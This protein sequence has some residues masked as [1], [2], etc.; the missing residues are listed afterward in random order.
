MSNQTIAIDDYYYDL[1]RQGNL[2][3]PDHAAR[4]SHAVLRALGFN[5]GGATKSK[6]AKALPPE[7]ARD[8]K[9]GWRLINIRSSNLSLDKFASDVARQ[10]GN[11]DPDFAKTAIRAVFAQIK[12]LVDDD[13][14]R[15]VARDLS[16]E[17]RAL[18]N[19][20]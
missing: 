15:A 3:T 10:S 17:V 18:W 9:R 20:A 11:T 1:M 4:V 13:V 6:L 2:R 7:L 19:A 16:P 8:L 5:L 14:T 12:S